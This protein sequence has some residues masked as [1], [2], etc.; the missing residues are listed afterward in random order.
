M[1]TK[2]NLSVLSI[3][4]AFVLA[5]PV[6]AMDSPFSELSGQQQL[7][8]DMLRE[9]VDF[10]T[11]A[12][13]PDE[14]RRALEAMIAR[15]KDAGFTSED[16]ELVNPGTGQ[17]GLV[18]RYRGLGNKRPLLLLAHMDVVTATAGAWAFPPFSLG[19][20]DGYYVGRG[21]SDNKAGVVQIFSNFIRL[22]Q[23]GWV[24]GR[25][26][27]AA[28]SGDEETDGAVA[29]WLANEG[30]ALIDAEYA[31]NTDAGG[32]EYDES[33]QHQAFWIQTSEKLYQTYVLTAANEGG[34]SSL[35]RPKNAIQDLALAITRL[36]EYEFPVVISDS[37]RMRLER[38]AANY[39]EAVSR[40]MLALVENPAN[41]EAARRLSAV[42]PY[43][44]ATL[45][46]TCT[47]TMLNG[48]HAEN[49]LPRDASVTV[50][51]RIMPGTPAVEVEQTIVSLVDGLNIEISIIYEGI[52]SEPSIIPAAFLEGN[53]AMVEA[54]W[55]D[56]P[57]IPNMSTGATDGLFYRNV[58]IPVYGVG[59]AF[60]KPDDIRA[61]GLDERLGILEFHESVDYW[62]EM[63]KTF[64]N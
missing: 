19:K 31:I 3:L 38:S 21:T 59:A 6:L 10:E 42:N 14:T 16:I 5:A 23:E 1:K 36:A 24:P 18:V 62:Y 9:I 8:E 60:F 58:G 61:H 28:I 32:G 63:L 7:S 13:H 64:A 25:D 20:K 35:P 4:M 57:V 26:L 54:R 43:F 46:T 17:Y 49:A 22:K 51:C 33:G 37:T 50:N 30:R 12:E 56:I 34:H 53:E 2:F 29:K 48:G 47:P 27:I 41:E 52:P 40:D 55:G 15:L 44:N 11:T 39:P 45:R